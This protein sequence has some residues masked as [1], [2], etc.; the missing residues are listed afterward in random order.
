VTRAS[1]AGEAKD[2][3]DLKKNIADKLNIPPN[4]IY[5]YDNY[6]TE[7]EKTLRI[8]KK[9]LD[10]LTKVIESCRI[11]QRFHS[12]DILKDYHNQPKVPLSQPASN[13]PVVSRVQPSPSPPVSRVQPSLSPVSRGQPSRPVINN[14]APRCPNSKCLNE[15]DPE[16][17][18]CPFCGVDI[19]KIVFPQSVSSDTCSNP[20]CR[21]PM[22]EMFTF[23]PKCKTPRQAQSQVQSQPQ[24]STCWSCQYNEVESDWDQ[25]CACGCWLI[26]PESC[27]GSAIRPAFFQCPKCKKKLPPQ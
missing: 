9:T 23:C 1:L 13:S 26:R 24:F 25:C 8:D 7:D 17:D 10:I 3:D 18:A 4:A 15:V 12:E 22:K 16:W 2:Q 11:Y 21:A 14:Q 20:N 19:P 6:T 5:M 27:C